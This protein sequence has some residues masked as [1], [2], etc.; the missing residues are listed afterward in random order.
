MQVVVVVV[1]TNIQSPKYMHIPVISWPTNP[2]LCPSHI[3]KYIA[4]HL[5]TTTIRRRLV[6]LLGNLV[7]TR[8]QCAINRS[9]T[10]A[11]IVAAA[12]HRRHVE[13][14]YGGVTARVCYY[15]YNE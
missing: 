10:A 1:L 7:G 4:A 5:P 15:F 13:S 6:L 14:L 8:S 3:F 12:I 11:A 9:M 2:P